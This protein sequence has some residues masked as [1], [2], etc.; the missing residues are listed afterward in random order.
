MFSVHQRLCADVFQFIYH[1][2]RYKII[3]FP[4]LFIIIIQPL[5][6]D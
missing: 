4:S 2:Q 6:E 3:S 5:P 1:G